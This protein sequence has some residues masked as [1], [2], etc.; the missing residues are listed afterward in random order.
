M[1]ASQRLQ[2]WISSGRS[3]RI[4]GRKVFVR[5]EVSEARPPLLLI[6]GYPTASYDW[7]HVW[8]RLARHF[9]LYALDLLGFGLSD[10]PRDT[11]Y[12]I[13]LQADLCTA[14]LDSVGYEFYRFF[15][16]QEGLVCGIL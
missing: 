8:P 10:K 3:A 4:E 6:H 1:N 16:M 12:P 13:S 7:V 14:F 11:S 5:T 2:D 15:R 9:S